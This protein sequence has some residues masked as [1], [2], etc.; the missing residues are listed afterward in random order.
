MFNRFKLQFFI[1]I[2]ANILFL[3]SL[4]GNKSQEQPIKDDSIINNHLL[5]HKIIKDDN[6]LKRN[7]IDLRKKHQSNFY[8]LI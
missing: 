3:E 7:S 4:S 8:I 6:I 2:L 1:I 5:Q